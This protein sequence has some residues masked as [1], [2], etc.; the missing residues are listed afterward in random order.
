MFQ[1][2]NQIAISAWYFWTREPPSFPARDIGTLHP[3]SPSDEDTD[4]STRIQLV[5]EHTPPK[6]MKVSWDCYSQCIYIYLYLYMIYIHII[7]IYIFIYLF[8]Y[9]FIYFFLFIHI[10]IYMCVCIWETKSSKPPASKDVFGIIF[11]YF[12]SL[13]MGFGEVS[14][15]VGLTQRHRMKTHMFR[16][17]GTEWSMS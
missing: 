17:V 16:N 4:F 8:I 9:I 11:W 2:T 5:V 15:E 6:N 3:R 10:Y 14:G 12:N 1:T 13:T 7:Y